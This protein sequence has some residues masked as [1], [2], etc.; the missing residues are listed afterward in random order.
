MTISTLNEKLAE[1]GAKIHRKSYLE[2]EKQELEQALSTAQKEEQQLLETLH[3]EQK[4]VDKLERLSFASLFHALKGSKEAEHH[5][6]V[7]ELMAAKTKLNRFRVEYNTIKE[8]LKAVKQAL[9]KIDKLETTYHKLFEEKKTLLRSQP[10][11]TG[12]LLETKID[13]YETLKKQE[14]E[15][16]EAIQAGESSIRLLYEA[17]DMLKSASR[18]A[19]YDAFSKKGLFSHILKYNRIERAQELLSRVQSSL[20]RSTRELSDVNL[21]STNLKVHIS[22]TTR[23]IDFWLDNIFTDIK[24]LNRINESLNNAESTLG[25]VNKVLSGIK[26]HEKDVLTQTEKLKKEIETIVDNA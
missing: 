2:S 7:G 22:D 9:V 16:T 15:L 21:T 26:T 6:Q 4:D 19:T 14:K 3:K 23:T 24:V 17:I 12:A 1:L 25:R 11:Q 18:W 5:E 10:N 20:N 13:H 8:D